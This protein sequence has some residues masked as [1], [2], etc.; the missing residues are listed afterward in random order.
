SSSSDTPGELAIEV[1]EESASAGRATTLA[2][3]FLTPPSDPAE[4]GE[5]ISGLLPDG[6]LVF[7]TVDDMERVSGRVAT[8]LALADARDEV[9]GRYGYG[10]GADAVL[11]P[12]QTP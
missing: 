4:R 9:F 5:L 1:A 6:P 7:S 3:V 8:V 2:E 10:S 12:W 11:P